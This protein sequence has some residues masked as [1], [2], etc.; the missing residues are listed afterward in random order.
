VITL[1]ALAL[2]LLAIIIGLFGPRFPG[3]PPA[4]AAKAAEPRTRG[5]AA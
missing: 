1:V 4:N 5:R 2:S 3:V